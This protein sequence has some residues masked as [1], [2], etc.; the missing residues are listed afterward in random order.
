MAQPSCRASV[1]TA[2]LAVA[3]LNRGSEATA[4]SQ[5]RD[6]QQEK[7]GSC[8]RQD[9]HIGQDGVLGT[10]RQRVMRQTIEAKG[11]I[12]AKQQGSGAGRPNLNSA[13]AARPTR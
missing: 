6:K 3:A 12:D 5:C 9:G 2:G 1:L 11:A 7:T 13:N 8:L 4:E 10:K